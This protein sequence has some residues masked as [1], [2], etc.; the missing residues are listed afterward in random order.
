MC[1]IHP[2]G[3]YSIVPLYFSAERPVVTRDGTLIMVDDERMRLEPG[4]KPNDEASPL[5]HTWLL[6]LTGAVESGA[7]TA[8]RDYSGDAVGED[9]ERQGRIIDHDEAGSMSRETQGYFNA[10]LG[11]LER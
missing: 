10:E 9:S 1:G 7:T 4:E 6:P 5:P 3:E 8:A 2:S 11:T